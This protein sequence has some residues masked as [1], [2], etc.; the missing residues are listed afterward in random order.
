MEIPA[1]ADNAGDVLNIEARKRLRPVN[2]E[3]GDIMDWYV[4]KRKEIVRNL[5][6]NTYGLQDSVSSKAIA[7]GQTD[8]RVQPAIFDKPSE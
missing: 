3:M 4:F 2:K 8:L 7:L 6:L 1:G 5:P